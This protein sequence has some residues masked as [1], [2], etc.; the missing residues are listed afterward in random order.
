MGHV[1]VTETGA[2][3]RY[4]HEQY[5]GLVNQGVLAPDDRV[6]LLEGVIVAVA[7]QSPRHA[8][9]VLRASS[10]LWRVV[11]DRASVAVQLPLIVGAHS[12][13]EPDV[14]VIPGNPPQYDRSHPT[15][16]LLVVEVA[17]SSL[18]QDRLTKAALYAAADVP[19]YW[20]VNLLDDCVEVFR[21]PE[22]MARRY[23]TRLM[24]RRGEELELVALPGASVA[25]DS[26]LPGREA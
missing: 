7:P 26:L 18:I 20:L 16:A 14:A 11:G 10:V 4:T 22:P 12:A 8:A 5:F 13:P 19:E 9:A 3:V 6:E 1:A 24:V 23:T 21:A 25:V 17:D 15:S 2:P